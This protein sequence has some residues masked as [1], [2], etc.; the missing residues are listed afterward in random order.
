MSGKQ[1]YL[2]AELLESLELEAS[3]SGINVDDLIKAKLGSSSFSNQN[4]NNLV[5]A[6]ASLVSR[7]Q[8]LEIILSRYC[9]LNEAEL[10]DL[11]YIRG[12]IEVQADRK[13]EVAKSARKREEQRSEL[14][15]KIRE[16]VEQY[17]N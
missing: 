11:G 4:Q 16:E 10:E 15:R 2:N 9:I 1:L 6:I 13:P 12:A 5:K 8:N 14:A 17:L 7:V 3:K